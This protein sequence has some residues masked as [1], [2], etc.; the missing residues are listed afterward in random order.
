MVKSALSGGHNGVSSLVFLKPSLLGRLFFGLANW[1][2]F[3]RDITGVA[4]SSHH[5]AGF[6][7]F[8]CM[9]LERRFG[10]VMISVCNGGR[11]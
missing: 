6:T 7:I 9:Y 1:R 5:L 4:F 2:G 10:V 3:L 8:M 11:D